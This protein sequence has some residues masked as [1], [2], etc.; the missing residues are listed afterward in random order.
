MVMA[1]DLSVALG[2]CPHGAADR[3]RRH[4]GAMALPSSLTA[5]RPA[6]RRW[7]AERLVAHMHGDK[8]VRDGKLN[9]ILAREIG[10]A[11]LAQDIPG[12]RVIGV[13][14]AHGAV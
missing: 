2:L 12:D 3:V 6:Q 11:F 5:G 7:S 8:K 14:R 10:A 13:L 9:F 1:F 4:F